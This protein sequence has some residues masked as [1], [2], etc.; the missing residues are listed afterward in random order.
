MPTNHFQGNVL[1]RQKRK[2]QLAGCG[3]GKGKD[4][5]AMALVSVLRSRDIYIL[6]PYRISFIFQ[7]I[8]RSIETI[9]CRMQ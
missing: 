4:V 9:G 1:D 5:A 8:H 2:L 3:F 7:L 6:T